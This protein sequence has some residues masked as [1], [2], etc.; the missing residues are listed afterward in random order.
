[1]ENLDKAMENRVWQRVLSRQDIQEE[2]PRRDNLKP[3][4]LAAQENTAACRSLS[5][6]LIGKQWEGLRRLELESGR[7]AQSLRGICAL[8]GEQVRLTPLPSPREAPRRSLEKCLRRSLRMYRELESR[9]TD[10]ELGPLFRSL[11]RKI[12]DHC[13]ALTEMLGRLDV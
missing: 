9:C 12:E 13:A 2:L 11:C 1:M 7:I 4:I 5:L 3:W 8:R 6:Q 10:P